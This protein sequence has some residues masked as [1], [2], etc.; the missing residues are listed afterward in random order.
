MRPVALW[1]IRKG[2]RKPRNTPS[3]TSLERSKGKNICKLR[4]KLGDKVC[5]RKTMNYLLIS[6]RDGEESGHAKNAKHGLSGGRVDPTSSGT[7]LDVES[8]TSISVS[9]WIV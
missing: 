8:N 3:G 9:G 7:V 4:N 1:L 5:Q 6:R 2:T